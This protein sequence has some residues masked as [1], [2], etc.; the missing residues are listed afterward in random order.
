MSLTFNMKHLLFL[1]FIGFTRTTSELRLTTYSSIQN[2]MNGN[3][4]QWSVKKS[5]KS[6]K[7]GII[8]KS[9]LLL[10]L[11][12]QFKRLNTLFLTT[13]LL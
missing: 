2:D 3:S 7:L 10:P 12:N 6:G 1:L 5:M 8:Y 4:D 13:Q 9:L 11:N